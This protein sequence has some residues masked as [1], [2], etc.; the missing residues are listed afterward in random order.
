MITPHC[1]APEYPNRPFGAVGTAFPKEPTDERSDEK[2]ALVAS[3]QSVD[4]SIGV[5]PDFRLC[6]CQA[7]LAGQ[8]SNMSGG[9]A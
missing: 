3:A 6:W 2:P 1:P 8:R 7:N 4:R 5:F 9:W